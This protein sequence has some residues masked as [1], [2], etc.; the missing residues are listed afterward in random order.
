MGSD[1]D[2]IPICILVSQLEVGWSVLEG[3][4][5]EFLQVLDSGGGFSEQV[6]FT[7]EYDLEIH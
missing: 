3:L 2:F 7:I 6:D 5:D 4:P 1:C